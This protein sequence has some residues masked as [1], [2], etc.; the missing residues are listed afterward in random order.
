MYEN[1]KNVLIMNWMIKYSGLVYQSLISTEIELFLL[2]SAFLNSFTKFRQ[3]IVLHDSLS[4]SW[5]EH[6]DVEMTLKL[7]RDDN[8]WNGARCIVYI[9]FIENECQ[10][11][12]VVWLFLLDSSDILWITSVTVDQV[13]S[14]I[15]DLIVC[16]LHLYIINHLICY[17][18]LIKKAWRGI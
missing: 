9:A 2:T 18:V 11:F 6:S 15:N 7:K 13:Y 16:Y 10:D 17:R 3:I 5:K 8:T 14:F 12:F 4:S 1:Y